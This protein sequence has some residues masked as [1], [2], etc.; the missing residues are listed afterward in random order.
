MG[1][2]TLCAPQFAQKQSSLIMFSL[3]F[4]SHCLVYWKSQWAKRSFLKK[5]Y[6]LLLLGLS[7]TVEPDASSSHAPAKQ[8]RC[9]FCL[10][11]LAERRGVGGAQEILSELLTRQPLLWLIIIPINSNRVA[12]FGSVER[13]GPAGF[14]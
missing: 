5:N 7:Q 9:I 14:S 13:A 12:T 10:P 3:D 8:D 2:W 1:V 4:P 11:S 6:Y